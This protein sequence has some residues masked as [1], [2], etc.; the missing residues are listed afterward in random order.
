MNRFASLYHTEAYEQAIT[1]AIENM[2]YCAEIDPQAERLLDI[3][4]RFY[5]VVEKW[6][7]DHTYHAPTLSSDLSGLYTT[8]G[9]SRLALD[10]K[11]W[12]NNITN[13]REPEARLDGIPHRTPMNLPLPPISDIVVS[14]PPSSIIDAKMNGMSPQMMSPPFPHHPIPPRTS[15][16]SHSMSDGSESMNGHIEFSFDG[17][18]ENWE[19]RHPGPGLFPVGHVHAGG[20]AAATAG[21]SSGIL[22]QTQPFAA[23]AAPQAPVAAPSPGF[24]PYQVHPETRIPPI[25]TLSPSVPLYHTSTFQGG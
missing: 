10:H 11:A 7:K 22:S 18:W 23:A 25:S 17:L 1:D 21:P 16:S 20:S 13:S 15:V 8:M 5:Q 24:A 19:K 6:T 12:V 3:M 9:N 4:N 2:R 14:Q